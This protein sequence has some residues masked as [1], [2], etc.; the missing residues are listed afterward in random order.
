LDAWFA[1]WNEPDP[2]RR[3][4]TLRSCCA[5]DLEFRDEWAIARGLPLL[6]QHISN[7]LAFMPGWHLESSDDVRI[8]RGEVLFGWRS[9]GPAGPVYGLNHARVDPDGRIRRVTGFATP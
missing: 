3:L 2:D 4:E 5:E 7:C 1:S 6:N 9:S 8:C